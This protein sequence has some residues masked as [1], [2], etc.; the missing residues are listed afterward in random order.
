MAVKHLLHQSPRQWGI[1]RARWR[2]QDVGRTLSWLAGYSDAGIVKVLKQLGFSRQR[3]LH[4]TQ[5]PDPNYRYKWQ[6]ILAAYQ[7]AVAHPQEVVLLFQDE[8]T[9]YRRARIQPSWQPRGGLQQRHPH[10]HG[11]NTQARVTAVLNALTGQVT[12]LQRYKV[13]KPELVTFYAQV[14][15]AYPAVRRLYLVQDNWPVHKLPSVLQAAQEQ[16]FSLLFLPT[17]A[18]WLNPIEK[19]WH[20]LRKDVLHNHS[21]SDDFKTLR[22]QVADF[23]EQF[24]SGSWNLLHYVGLLS[25]EELLSVSVLNC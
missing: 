10:R 5:S 17:Y 4:F 14:R 24:A 6:A 8:F 1:P 12:F 13:G 9:Y 20:W 3:C 18:S 7:D 21:L 16:R 15:A 11:P 19:L 22:L 25:K 23:L 2:L